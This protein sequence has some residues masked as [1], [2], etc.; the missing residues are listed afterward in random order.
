[1]NKGQKHNNSESSVAVYPRWEDVVAPVVHKIERMS[2][3]NS[4]PKAIATAPAVV[5]LCLLSSDDDDDNKAPGARVSS[6]ALARLPAMSGRENTINLLLD[7][8]PVY[9]P[10]AFVGRKRHRAAFKLDPNS[11]P[12]VEVLEGPVQG[13]PASR[14]RFKRDPNEDETQQQEQQPPEYLVWEV[15]PDADL[16]HVQETLADHGGSVPAVLS[17]FAEHSYP[18][19]KAGASA[20]SS[21]KNNTQPG[22]TIVR[23]DRKKFKHDY[24]SPASFEPAQL[25]VLQA[26]NLLLADFPF[27]SKAGSQ[28]ILG[29]FRKHYAIAHDNIMGAIKGTAV[30]KAGEELQDVQYRRMLRALS[31]N[32][33][34]D[35]QMKRMNDLIK[36]PKAALKTPRRSMPAPLVTDMTLL[37]EMVY[38]KQKQEEWMD[39]ARQRSNRQ[40]NKVA[41][42]RAGTAMECS[43]CYD[44]VA[45]GDMVACRDEGHLFCVDC[46]KSFAENQVFGSGNLGFDKEKKQPALELKCFHGDGCSSGFNR[47]CLEK[48]LP[49]KVLRKHDELQFQVSI[50]RA[51]LSDVIECPKCGFQAALDASLKVF[52]CPVED[53]QYESC[54]DCREAAHVPLRCDEVEKET[55]TKGRLTVEEAISN[56]KIRKC[57][58]CSK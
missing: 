17:H 37:D 13:V 52:S 4:C 34:D 29:K 8:S 35:D 23:L 9:A 47:A 31:G 10:R 21:N 42:Q 20:Q 39:I 46:L 48:A 30:A 6:V 56:A 24:M 49:L 12:Q 1:M 26:T 3:S 22:Q 50:E 27:L 43:C 44:N 40:K 36:Y 33:L 45:I 41:C 28:H 38:V 55:E 2:A 58:K 51:G 25:Y 18:K 5:D 32:R 54:R 53:C 15:F 16:Q 19:A 57:P 11:S 14:R 7:D